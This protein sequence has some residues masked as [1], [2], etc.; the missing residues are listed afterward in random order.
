MGNLSLRILHFGIIFFK[1][2][3]KYIRNLSLRIFLDVLKL[4]YANMVYFCYDLHLYT[5][6]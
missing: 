5:P 4:N 1:D 2:F 6:G 3:K